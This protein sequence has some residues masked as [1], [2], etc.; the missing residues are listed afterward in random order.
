[1]LLD[2]DEWQEEL[3]STYLTTDRQFETSR[4]AECEGRQTAVVLE[5]GR[6]LH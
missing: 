1:V 6:I 2:N 5:M 4:D 3:D